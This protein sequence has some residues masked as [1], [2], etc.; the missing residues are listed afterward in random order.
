V[1]VALGQYALEI[2]LALFAV[3]AALA[4]WA[5]LHKRGSIRGDRV[6]R[7]SYAAPSDFS[8]ALEDLRREFQKAVEAAQATGTRAAAIGEKVIA[9]LKP[10]ACPRGRAR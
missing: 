9:A 10:C 6:D 5:V 8:R 1:R 3:I 7:E 2:G 4:A